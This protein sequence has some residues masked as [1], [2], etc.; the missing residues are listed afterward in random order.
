MV[1]GLGSP[2]PIGPQAVAELESELNG[3]VWKISSHHFPRV[4]FNFVFR[5]QCF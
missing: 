4:L 2:L 3:D 5:G 1:T